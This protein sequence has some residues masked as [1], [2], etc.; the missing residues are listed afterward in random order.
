LNLKKLRQKV[1]IV[2]FD[3]AGDHGEFQKQSP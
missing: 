3:S 1:F 2:L